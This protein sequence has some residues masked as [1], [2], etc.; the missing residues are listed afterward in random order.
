MSAETKQEEIDNCWKVISMKNKVIDEQDVL[1]KL[2]QDQLR[3]R[4]SRITELE[5]DNIQKAHR[6]VRLSAIQNQFN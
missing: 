6:I 1:I 4:E 2:L 3:S 5:D